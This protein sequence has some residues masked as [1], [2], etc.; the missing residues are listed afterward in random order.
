MYLCV[1]VCVHVCVSVF[2]WDVCEYLGEDVSVCPCM[3]MCVYIC[4]YLFIW[5]RSSGGISESCGVLA[6]RAGFLLF[7]KRLYDRVAEGAGSE[8]DYLSAMS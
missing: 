4:G 3:C 8:A 6:H 7:F 2:M 1:Y 5:R